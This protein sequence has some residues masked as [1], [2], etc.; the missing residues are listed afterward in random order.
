M[1]KTEET[2]KPFQKEL[3]F[4]LILSAVIIIVDQITKYLVVVSIPAWS[5]GYEFFG[6][7]LRII[8]VY[9]PGVAFSIG[10]GMPSLFRSLVFGIIPAAVIVIILTIY[11]KSREFTTLQRWCLAAI[12]GGGVGNLIDRFFRP[13]GV[14]DFID[15]AVYG[16]LGYERWPTFNVADSAIVV[17]ITIMIISFIKNFVTEIKQKKKNG[18]GED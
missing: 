9:N 4:P 18:S 2:N 11:F 1:E 12:I 17:S 7:A 13:E 8:H 15:V 6:G 14:V 5:V 10:S 16:F 3:F